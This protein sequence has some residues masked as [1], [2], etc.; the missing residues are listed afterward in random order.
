MNAEAF[1]EVIASYNQSTII[2]QC[3]FMVL[4]FAGFILALFQKAVWFSKLALGFTNIFIGIIFF[5]V[6]GTEPIQ[7][8]FAAPL[9]IT[10]GFLFIYEA[11]KRKNNIF[12]RPNA[13]QWFLLLLF[14]I[15]PVVS[16]ILGNVFPKMVVYIMPCP[17]IS[18][19]IV[20]YSCYRDKNKLLLVLMAIWGL[21]GIKAFFVNAFEDVILLLCGFYCIKILITEFQ[22]KR[23]L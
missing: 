5:L 20:I 14:L 2:W 8:Y 1:W 16:I 11:I 7:T 10:T 12:S 6:F 19:S 21:T 13:V 17:I 3:V 15:Y 4:I 23:I 18:I 22:K 9:F